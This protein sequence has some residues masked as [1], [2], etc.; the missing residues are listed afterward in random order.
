MRHKLV[1]YILKHPPTPIKGK[2]K[3]EKKNKKNGDEEAD[4]PTSPTK[5]DSAEGS[6]DELTKRIVAEAAELPTADQDADDDNW[7]VDTSEEAVAERMKD[8]AIDMDEDDELEPHESLDVWLKENQSAKNNDIYKKIKEL[9]ISKEIDIVLK[10]LVLNL[11]PEDFQ[12]I[13]TIEKQINKRVK[14]FQKV[15]VI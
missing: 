6:D 4:S 13:E 5:G 14:L 12:K 1:T 3:K 2:G 8:L 7:A 11:F 9:G 10:Y 15:N